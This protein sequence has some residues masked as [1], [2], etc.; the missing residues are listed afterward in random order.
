MRFETGEK[1]K[2]DWLF[3]ILDDEKR[4][5][6]FHNVKSKF[7][8]KRDIP[9]IY[10]SSF[11]KEEDILI[12]GSNRKINNIN[13]NKDIDLIIISDSFKFLS[14]LARK[15]LIY[16]KKINI[17]SFCFTRNEFK[18]VLKQFLEGHELWCSEL[19]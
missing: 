14:D 19:K 11:I 18:I 8:K 1:I 6:E 4:K 7:L 3:N 2:M 12:F 9:F 10:F 5:N 17:D 13:Y 16:S 15:S